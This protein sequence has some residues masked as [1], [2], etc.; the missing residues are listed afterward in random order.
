MKT[1]FAGLVAVT[2]AVLVLAQHAD[3]RKMPPADYWK[4]VRGEDVN[5]KGPPLADVLEEQGLLEIFE[6]VAPLLGVDLQAPTIGEQTDPRDLGRIELWR[7]YT[8]EGAHA[9]FDRKLK[10][11]ID[12]AS[13]AAGLADQEETSHDDGPTGEEILQR[14]HAILRAIASPHTFELADV[15]ETTGMIVNG[16]GKKE[17]LCRKVLEHEGIPTQGFVMLQFNHRGDVMRFINQPILLPESMQVVIEQD[18]AERIAQEFLRENGPPNWKMERVFK[19]IAYPNNAFD[20]DREEWTTDTTR[21][22]LCW[23][24]EGGYAV[25]E[26]HVHPLS[27]FVDCESGEIIG[28]VY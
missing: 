13:A 3:A 16:V 7:V 23:H 14:V 24:V 21:T 11:L 8:R 12:F 28:G 10:V 17:W 6:G 5:P 2:L 25:G 19:A 18:E 26:D 1:V 27:I 22:R 4:V 20:R 9:D 15:E